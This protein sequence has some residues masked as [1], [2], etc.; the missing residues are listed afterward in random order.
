MDLERCNTWFGNTKLL[1]NSTVLLQ[2][3]LRVFKKIC[4]PKYLQW[5][6]VDYKD[7]YDVLAKVE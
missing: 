3:I 5:Q 2:Y 4:K 1:I 7:M 6:Q